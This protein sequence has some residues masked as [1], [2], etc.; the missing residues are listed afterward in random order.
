[1]GIP[2]PAQ[3]RILQIQ[4][5]RGGA[6]N[7]LKALAS[8]P[9]LRILDLLSDQVRNVGEI[10]EA[11]N[12]PPSTATLHVS[13]L[14]E[15]GLVT[16]ELQPGVRGLQKVCARTYDII[17]VE[18]PRAER[19]SEETVSFAMPLGAYVECQV[20]PSCGLAGAH[21][22]LGLFDDPVSFYEPERLNAQ[23][24]WFRRGY[25]EYHFPN[26]I[27][28]ATSLDS[29]SFSL[30]LCSEAPLHSDDWQ[31]DITVWVNGVEI[32]TWTSPADFGGERGLLTPQWWEEWNSQYGLLKVWQ[33]SREG[34]FVD[35]LRCSNVT[36][37]DLNIMERPFIAVRIGVKADAQHA[38]GVNIFGRQFGN[39]PQDLV[40]RL[41]Y[42]QRRHGEPTRTGEF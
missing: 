12:M 30:E 9:R 19:P 31:S 32:G 40:L 26:R 35:G 25:V 22:I 1:M 14:E 4:T 7:L 36:L 6:L 37:D 27:P 2:F 41:R 11:L 23:L 28:L 34:S 42:R 3:R 5:S 13:T 38:G 29:L 15:Q 17:M 16:T 10:A 24:L 33:V 20:T 39:Y 18:L 21:G 8:E